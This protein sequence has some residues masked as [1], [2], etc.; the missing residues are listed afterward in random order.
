M[1]EFRV[2]YVIFHFSTLHRHQSL[3]LPTIIYILL[4]SFD[5]F[6]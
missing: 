3:W 5:L 6:S 1:P 2:D 4:V